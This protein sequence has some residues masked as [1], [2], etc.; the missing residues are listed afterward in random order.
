MAESASHPSNA[1]KTTTNKPRWFRM[2]LYVLA[3]VVGYWFGRIRQG[4]DAPTQHNPQVT[5][6]SRNSRASAF[7]ESMLKT[8]N[9][10]GDTVRMDVDSGDGRILALCGRV[11][12]EGAAPPADGPFA[13]PGGVSG[14]MKDVLGGEELGTR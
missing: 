1:S 5:G 13:W 2:T 7:V 6:C 3:V 8:I 4:G 14:A 11:F 9:A 12:P 10:V